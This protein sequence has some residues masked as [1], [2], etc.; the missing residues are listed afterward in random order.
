MRQ[1]KPPDRKR[2]RNDDGPDERGYGRSEQKGDE[3]RQNCRAISQG[4][5]CCPRLGISGN[6]TEFGPEI[7]GFSRRDHL[8]ASEEVELYWFWWAERKL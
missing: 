1:T 2:E 6:G 3:Y 7:P 5:R 8:T 4:R